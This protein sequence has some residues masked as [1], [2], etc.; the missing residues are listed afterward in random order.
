ML[1]AIERTPLID[2]CNKTKCNDWM[3]DMVKTKCWAFSTTYTNGSPHPHCGGCPHRAFKAPHQVQ[4][5][6]STN[7]W[8]STSSRSKAFTALKL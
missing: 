7:A 1:N 3:N 5:D 8:K 4:L 6:S 2:S